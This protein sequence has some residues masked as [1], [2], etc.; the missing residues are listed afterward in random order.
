M[1]QHDFAAYASWLKLYSEEFKVAI[2]A[3]VFMTNHVHLL[4][5][6]TS[7]NGVSMM[8]Q[9][10][11]RRYVRHFNHRHQRTGTLW[12]GRFKSNVIQSETYLLNCYRYIEL[13]PV[14]AN[15][16]KDPADYVWS[17]YGCN[18]LGVASTLCTAHDE[19]LKLGS[20]KNERLETYRALFKTHMDIQLIAQIR[21]AVNKGHALGHQSFKDRLVKIYGRRV[22]SARIG[23]PKKVSS[24]PTF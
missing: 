18:G 19:Y 14:R 16:V 15:M 12:E 11:G 8:M 20:G 13:N 23:R 2:H 6:P 21:K 9:A 1:D 17:S 4:V 3:W 24:D 10:L 22:G 5:T 7:W